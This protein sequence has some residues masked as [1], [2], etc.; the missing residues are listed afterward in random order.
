MWASGVTQP[1]SMSESQLAF[2]TTMFCGIIVT[3]L[4]QPDPFL[5]YASYYVFSIQKFCSQLYK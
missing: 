2:V 5:T 1:I 4:S 3:P